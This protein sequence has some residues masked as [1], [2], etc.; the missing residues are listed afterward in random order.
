VDLQTKV[1]QLLD[2]LGL[3]KNDFLICE[4]PTTMRDPRAALRVEQ[5][6]TIFESLARD[7]SVQVPGRLNPRTVQYEVMGLRGKQLTRAI[8]KDT[9]VQIVQ[10][11]FATSLHHLGFD[12]S[13]GNLKRNQDIVDALLVG[14]LGLTRVQGARA[15]GAPAESFFLERT[16]RGTRRLSR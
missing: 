12:P 14:A 11:T 3:G 2:G 5:V 9:A 13:V 6:R 16:V 15:G 1:N 4:A 10:T 7:R 8:V